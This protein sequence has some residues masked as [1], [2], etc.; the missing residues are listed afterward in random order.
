MTSAPYLRSLR[1]MARSSSGPL[2]IEKVGE[3]IDGDNVDH[4]IGRDDH[5]IHHDAAGTDRGSQLSAMQSN[6]SAK[7][8]PDTL[9]TQY[10]HNPGIL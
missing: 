5:R 6:V 2:A 8:T 10:W 9:R 1:T 4:A 3:L 7:L